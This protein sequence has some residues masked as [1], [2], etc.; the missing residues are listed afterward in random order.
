MHLLEVLWIPLFRFQSIRRIWAIALI[1]VNGAAIFF[2]D[3]A[4][5]QIAII[6]A[7]SAAIAMMVIYGN[8]GF[9]RLLGIGH[10]FWVPM[11]CYFVID[12]PTLEASPQLFAWLATLVALNSLSLIIDAVD[13][14]RYWNGER[15][16]HYHWRSPQLY[17]GL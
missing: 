3:T 9:V 11:L 13:L 17:S 2:A 5:G 1:A 10:I 16:P 14:F 6:A 4:Y 15:Q 8:L 7:V 12:M